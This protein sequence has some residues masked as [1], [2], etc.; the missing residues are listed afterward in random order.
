MPLAY[1]AKLLIEKEL[2][3]KSEFMQKLSAERAGYQAN[4]RGEPVSGNYERVVN[5]VSML[6]SPAGVILFITFFFVR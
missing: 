6:T 5:A 4:Y 1:L 2:I 3:T